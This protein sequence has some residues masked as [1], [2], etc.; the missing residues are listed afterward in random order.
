[1]HLKLISYGF[2]I[3]FDEHDRQINKFKIKWRKKNIHCSD[4][5]ISNKQTK[6]E[7]KN[8]TNYYI[9][10]FL[11]LFWWMCGRRLERIT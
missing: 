4:R 6:E 2:W 5:W 11:L 1:M 3:E 7:E 9:K 10:R 8:A